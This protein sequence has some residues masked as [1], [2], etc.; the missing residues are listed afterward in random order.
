MVPS[1]T[2]MGSTTAV[3]PIIIKALNVLLP[4]TLP[5]AISALPFKAESTLITNSGAE[6]PKATMVRPI[7]RSEIRKRLATAAE[8][9][10]RPFAPSNIRAKPPI[11]RRVSNIIECIITI[12]LVQKY[13]FIKIGKNIQIQK[14]QGTPSFPQIRKRRTLHIRVYLLSDN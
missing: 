10:V 5:I 14:K 4:T 3:Q 2:L 9:S 1:P 13:I 11:K 6:V 7:T 8:P 12:L